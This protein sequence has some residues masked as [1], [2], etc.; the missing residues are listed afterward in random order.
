MNRCLSIDV[1]ADT[2]TYRA[3]TSDVFASTVQDTIDI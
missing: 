3:L 1:P 2:C